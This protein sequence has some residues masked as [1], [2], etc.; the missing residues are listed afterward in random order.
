MEPSFSEIDIAKNRGVSLVETC[1]S[2]A[3]LRILTPASGRGTAWLVLASYGGGMVQGD[4]VRL[5][6]S[7]G[8][9]TRS[10]IGTQSSSRVYRHTD[11]KTA[12]QEIEHSPDR[13][14]ERKQSSISIN[15]RRR[16]I[17]KSHRESDALANPGRRAWRPRSL[18][19]ESLLK[20]TG[21]L[22]LADCYRGRNQM[23]APGG[24]RFFVGCAGFPHP[25]GSNRRR[26]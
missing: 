12:T 11:A 21:L 7:F 25:A 9:E 4:A 13:S 6:G 24:W 26:V 22:L 8:P 20:S 14:A 23:G 17:K 18:Q 5:R 19:G 3:P 16:R 1:R 15:D 10:F 2:A